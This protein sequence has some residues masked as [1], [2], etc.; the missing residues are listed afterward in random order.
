MK[1]IEAPTVFHGQ[2]IWRRNMRTKTGT[3]LAVIMALLAITACNTVEG[4]GK[5]VQSAGETVE[6]AA[7]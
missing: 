1:P 3:K 4:V 5:D 6:D 2:F 7:N